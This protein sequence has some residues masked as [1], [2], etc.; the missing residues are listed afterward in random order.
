MVKSFLIDITKT[1]INRKKQIYGETLSM[2][3]NIGSS[4]D[5]SIAVENGNIYTV[6]F[7]FNNTYSSGGDDDIFYRC[8][9][10]G[11]NWEAI[12]IISEPIENG[13]RNI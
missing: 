5:P 13:V 10:S 12:Q 3:N 7:D 8:K 9:L 4:R 1:I 11:Y 6:W 2:N